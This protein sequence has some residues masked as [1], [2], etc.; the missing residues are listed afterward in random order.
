[1]F[2]N[3]KSNIILLSDKTDLVDMNRTLGVHK[4]AYTLRQAGY[5]VAVVHFLSVFTV[6]EIKYLLTN[7]ISNKTLFVGVSNYFY[8]PIDELIIDNSGSVEFNNMPPGCILPH[9]PR[10]N[11]PIKNL[12]KQLNPNCK[13]AVGGP[14]AI[15]VGYNKIFDYVVTG[16]SEMSSVALARHLEN[17]TKLS[18]T[19]Y[20]SVHG[21][22]ILN[23]SKAADYDFGSSSMEF[24]E[25]DAIL[26]KETLL[27]EIG[28]GCIFKCAFCSHPLN[29]KKKLDY[30]R[31]HKSIREELIKNYERFGVTNYLMV[32]DTFNDSVKKCKEFYDMAMTLPF[33]INWW[34]YIRLDLMAAHPETIEYLFESGLRAAYFGI[35]TLNPKVGSVIGKG[36][37]RQK[38][39]KTAQYIKD[40]YG[41]RVTLHG[42]FIFGLPHESLESM[43]ESAEFLLSGDNPLDSWQLQVCRINNQGIDYTHGFVSDID[44]NFK[45]YGYVDQGWS[46]VEDAEK[47]L[48]TNTNVVSSPDT[49]LKAFV[50]HGMNWKNEY[51]CRNEVTE[52]VK[53]VYKRKN[54]MVF[55]SASF[56]IASLGLPVDAVLNKKIHEHK[57][58]LYNQIKLKRGQDYKKLLFSKLGIPEFLS[59]LPNIHTY[60]ELLTSGLLVKDN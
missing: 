60:S 57:W 42:S 59:K 28:R 5:Q 24:S 37:T 3:S 43:Q 36:G 17:S 14:T 10:F 47:P 27:L 44:V 12:I 9:G 7:L 49:G 40:K 15:D 53:E 21:P 11:Q 13:L 39:F 22:I 56:N 26:P 58:H 45:K 4:V 1:M 38:L 54:D 30:L 20:K 48:S 31:D 41:D 2:D 16:Y 29:G 25:V 18:V 23:D 34:G 35:E 6:Q 55:G 32:D 50:M 52:L 8:M 33:K 46:T 51:T 19:S